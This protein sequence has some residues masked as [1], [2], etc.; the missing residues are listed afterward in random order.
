MNYQYPPHFNHPEPVYFKGHIDNW[1]A[2]MPDLIGKPNVTMEIGALHGGAALFIMDTYG[3]LDG[4]WHYIVDPN[5]TE[6]IKVN[7]APYTKISYLQGY[8]GDIVRNMTHG[9]K[10]KDFLDL[11]YIDGNHMAKY[12]LEDAVLSFHC[13]KVGG[14]MVFDDY[15]WG[16]DQPEHCQPKTGIESF[17]HSYGTYFDVLHVGWQVILKKK[18]YELTAEEKASNY[19]VT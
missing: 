13:L 18:A 7:I 1:L 15:G 3:K 17:M 6:Y 11:V 2:T 14:Y 5:M 19:I 16:S 9:G 12:V 10:A 4:S 8:S